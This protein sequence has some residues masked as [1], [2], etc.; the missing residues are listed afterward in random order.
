MLLVS[1]A[2]G[3]KM[4]DSN[5]GFKYEKIAEKY[6]SENGYKILEKNFYCRMGEIDIIALRD[7]ML[8]FVEVKGRETIKYGY[9]REAVTKYKQ[10]KIIKSAQYYFMLK[11]SGEVP[12]QFD[13]IEIIIESKKI[14]HIENA[15]WA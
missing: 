4:Y 10:K 14:N 6:L 15:F 12:C 13:V 8:H 11:C 3:Y 2:A 9:P 7:G 5:K 1:I